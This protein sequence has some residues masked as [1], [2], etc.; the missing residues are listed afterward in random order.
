V[1]LLLAI[2]SDPTMGFQEY[3]WNLSFQKDDL[4]VKL[5]MDAR[6]EQPR[7]TLDDA[8]FTVNFPKP[9]VLDEGKMSYLGYEF[10]RDQVGKAKV[11]RLFRASVL[12]LTTHTMVPISS[13]KI[14]LLAST[15]SLLETFSESIV[16]DLYVNAY[17]SALYPDRLPDLAYANSLAFSRMK[18]TE[19]IFN[20]ATRIMAAILARFNIG[21]VKGGLSFEEE[22][23][24]NQLNSV[25]STLRKTIFTSFSDKQISL[26]EAM[27]KTAR[28]IIQD[29]DPY[30]PFL[31]APSMPY[32]ERIGPCSVFAHRKMSSESEIEAIFRKSL[33]TLGCTRPL[34]KAIDSCWRK[35]TDIEA[36]QAFDS[37]IHEGDRQEKILSKLR[38]YVAGTHLKSVEFPEE[39]YTQ[40]LRTRTLLAGGSR[41]LLDSLRVAQ[42]ALDEDPGKEMGQ[43]DLTSVIQAILSKKPATDVFFKDEY[44]SKSYAWSILFD[45]SASMNVKGEFARALAIVVAEATKELLMDPGSWTLFAFSDRFYVLKDS[46]EAYTQR[47]RARIGG[48]RFQGLTYMPDAIQVAGQILAK[49]YDEQRFLIVISDGWPYGYDDMPEALKASIVSVQKKG[50]IVI[51]IGVET[52]KMASLLRL[53]SP[54]YSQKDLIKK[55]SRIYTDASATALET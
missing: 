8:G 49:R 15:R 38:G 51:G 21:I 28:K 46:A 37:E 18:S 6:I 2:L 25:L 52:E 10:S 35:E 17:I 26:E 20:P 33:D 34:E 29:L 9:R 13:G 12:H 3:A 14:A 23:T 40:Y 27:T 44:L 11:G 50:I 24:L 36:L 5:R 47:V 19:R 55:F 45:A 30:G 54:V 39:D 7:F 53:S 43:L 42:D 16:G 48:L 4:K 32:T 22:K 1:I 31:E 41:R